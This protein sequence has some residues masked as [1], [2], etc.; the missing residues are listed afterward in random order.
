MD[1]YPHSPLRRTPTSTSDNDL[2]DT[3]S[4]TAVYSAS[5]S[6]ASSR[7]Q[8]RVTGRTPSAHS[9]LASGSIKNSDIRK[10]V[11]AETTRAS[12]DRSSISMPPPSTKPSVD[13]RLSTSL[14]ST[15]FQR[16]SEEVPRSP[17]ASVKSFD[18]RIPFGASPTAQTSTAFDSTL[19]TTASSP[20]A[21]GLPVLSPPA[22]DPSVPNLLDTVSIASSQVSSS[23][24]PPKGDLSVPTGQSLT[25]SF[26]TDTPDSAL[27]TR[28]SRSTNP[29]SV[30][31]SR[32]LSTTGSSKND[33]VESENKMSFGRI[34]VCALDVKARSRPSRQILTRLQ[35]D[36]D[37]E[38]IVF[39]D[40]AILDEGK[41]GCSI[42]LLMM[43]LMVFS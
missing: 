2:D 32:R 4:L 42:L 39:G 6:T 36:G 43:R 40:K 27:P 5:S 3:A 14:N 41:S 17:P 21:P 34:G 25:P 29:R 9:L 28:P 26:K 1:S 35:G 18:D 33:S 15:K 23:S 20:H 8:Q 10:G 13:R 12:A 11:H 24:Q 38:V 22:L 37:F 16:K 7:Q 31:S 19:V 30:S